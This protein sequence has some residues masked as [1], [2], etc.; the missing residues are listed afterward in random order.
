MQ[1]EIDIDFGSINPSQDVTPVMGTS[2][3]TI[4]ISNAKNS[5]DILDA[6]LNAKK[7]EVM[8]WEDCILP[9]RG[10]Y[11]SWNTDR[12]RVKPLTQTAE[13]ILATQ[14][15]AESGQ[16]IDY[17]F[18]EFVEFPDGFKSEDLLAGDRMF[19][20]FYLR[21][22]TYGNMYEFT[23]TCPN[24]ECLDVNGNRTKFPYQYDL[25]RL[26][27]TIKQPNPRIGLEP[28]KVVLPYLS[29]I[30]N[31]EFYVH[32]RFLRG[33]DQIQTKK[34]RKSDKRSQF[35]DLFTESITKCIVSVMGSDDPFKISQFVETKLHDRDFATIREFISDNTPSMDPTAVIECP[36]C[37]TEFNIELPITESFFRSAATGR[38]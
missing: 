32:V 11:Y 5:T 10:I 20:L 14:R 2:R 34:L 13:K 12:V 22:I 9:S 33:Y 8:P 16:S 1:D 29:S 23:V 28:F 19:I 17:L 26:A 36:K 30:V 21:G 37:G 7:E 38:V 4:D 24:P 15:L 6:V 18:R 3:P 35:N 27:A 25:N 31:T